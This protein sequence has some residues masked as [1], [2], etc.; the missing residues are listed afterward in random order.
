MA[1]HGFADHR[2]PL[3]SGLILRK[4]DEGIEE[5]DRLTVRSVVGLN[6][7]NA[8]VAYLSACSTAENKE[9]ILADGM[10]HVVSGFQVVGFPHV[11]GCLWQSDNTTCVT[12]ANNFI[13]SC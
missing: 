7:A 5:Q 9:K 6:L 10:I 13:R 11:V 3:S 2:D 4:C 8:H 12:V 1:C